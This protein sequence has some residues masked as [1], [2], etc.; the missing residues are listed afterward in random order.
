M[1]K[2]VCMIRKRVFKNKKTPLL[3]ILLSI[4]A[5]SIFIFLV[6]P[7][8]PLPNTK[9]EDT[10]NIVFKNTI[11]Y[12]LSDNN[13]QIVDV[14]TQ[15]NQSGSSS[16]PGDLEIIQDIEGQYIYYLNVL[17]DL[18]EI[19]YKVNGEEVNSA[20]KFSLTNKQKINI[21]LSLDNLSEGFIKF[22]KRKQTVLL[23]V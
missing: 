21:D 16:F 22:G 8:F 18:H 20:N 9:L 3:F 7:G 5:L 11:G 6:F 14:G 4:V 1:E 12:G 10:Q 13:D 23:F 2:G 17:K 19:P 15:I